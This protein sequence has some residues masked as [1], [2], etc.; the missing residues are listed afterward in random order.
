VQI[1][2]LLDRST[3]VFKTK[4]KAGKSAGNGKSGQKIRQNTVYRLYLKTTTAQIFT[5]MSLFVSPRRTSRTWRHVMFPSVVSSL[6]HV[7]WIMISYNTLLT[8]PFVMLYIITM[9]FTVVSCFMSDITIL[10]S[11]VIF[12]KFHNNCILFSGSNTGRIAIILFVPE[13][14]VL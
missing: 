3:R 12:T 11:N 10:L 5:Q 7:F 9:L 14:I 4:Q 1:A 2:E 8:Q 6:C 13:E